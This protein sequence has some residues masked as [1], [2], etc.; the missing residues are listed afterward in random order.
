MNPINIEASVL[1]TIAPTPTQTKT[2]QAK[3]NAFITT[4]SKNIKDAKVI[5]GGSVAKGTFFTSKTDIDVFVQFDYD[6]YKSK[7]SK[8]S[9]L[10]QLALKLSF[11]KTK[12]NR[13]HGS[14]DYFQLQ[15]EGYLFE[16]VPILLISQ[17]SK[18]I[19][20]TDI[21]PLHALW[22]NKQPNEIKNQIRLA[23]QFAKAQGCY[24][25]ESYIGGFSGYVLEILTIHYKS[26]HKL[27]EASQKWKK[28][29][30]IDVENY[31]KGKDIFMEIDI[32]KLNSPIIVV[33]PVDKYRN[34]SA[35]LNKEKFNQFKTAAKQYLKSSN[36]SFFENQEISIQ[37]ATEI[38]TKNKR[39]LIYIEIGPLVGKQD[40]IGCKL[41][42]VF[43]FLKVKL[44]GFAIKE[45]NWSWEPEQPGKFYLC[46][47]KKQLPKE[48]I[49]QGPPITMVD[50]VTNFK[51]KNFKNEIY[52]EAGI[53]YA[54][55]SIK[56]RDLE[57]V[58]KKL[59]E[60]K[61]VI[62]KIKKVNKLIINVQ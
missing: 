20:I 25:A 55:V 46:T 39:N 52:E 45:S 32:A 7:S 5:L 30:I 6:L 40:V 22:V 26:F 61:Y 48:L 47:A 28:T 37:L 29:T 33:D 56:T 36:S 59:L 54:K 12:I 24:G 21:S 34:A 27:I 57:P 44:N 31:H 17:S 2:V 43:D 18:A 9:D 19:N 8:L 4:L 62:E 16:I 15:H 51:K 23:K 10:L 49:K 41:L 58:V 42:K 11:P 50:A 13:V 53:I 35:A 38:A 60:A 1:Q 3:A 14:R